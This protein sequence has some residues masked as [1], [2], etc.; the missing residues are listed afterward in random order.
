MVGFECALTRQA[1]ERYTTS[2]G[3]KWLISDKVLKE[4]DND[5]QTIINCTQEGDVVSFDVT[6]VIQPASLV[7]IPWRLTLSSHVEDDFGNDD[8][9]HSK[10]RSTFTCPRENTGI[11]LVQ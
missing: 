7:T 1:K 2:D 3:R 9:L 5:L 10:T 11:F 8:F 6:G 4:V